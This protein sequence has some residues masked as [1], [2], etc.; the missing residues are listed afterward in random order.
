MTPFEGS[1]S[2]FMRFIEQVPVMVEW[3][4][5]S[6]A[7]QGASLALALAKAYHPEM[8]LDV[9]TQGFPADP[10]SGAPMQDAV[11]NELVSTANTYAGRVERYVITNDFMP[12][13]VPD[14]DPQQSPEHIDYAAEHPFRAS[15]NGTLTT[16]PPPSFLLT[17][18]ETGEDVDLDRPLDP[19]S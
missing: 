10:I 7:H 14:E 18:S 3:W 1:F 5:R 11:A 16:Y 8:S 17:D 4:N 19:V 6:S 13:T 12:T 15:L 2:Q 9:V